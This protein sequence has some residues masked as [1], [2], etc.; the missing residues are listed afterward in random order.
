M[1][2][3]SNVINL[4]T[5]NFSNLVITIQLLTVKKKMQ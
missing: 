5:N 3:N 4:I 2:L 1:T